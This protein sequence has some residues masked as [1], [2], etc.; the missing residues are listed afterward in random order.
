[1]LHFSVR[2]LTLWEGTEEQNNVAPNIFYQFLVHNIFYLSHQWHCFPLT[3]DGM[4]QGRKQVLFLS[5][6]HIL[7]DV[8]KWSQDWFAEGQT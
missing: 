6:L 4:L 7:H 5:Y 8:W 3:I 1:M 2:A